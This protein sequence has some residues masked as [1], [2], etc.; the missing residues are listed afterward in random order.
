MRKLYLSQRLDALA[1]ALAAELQNEPLTP[2]TKARVFVPHPAMKEW[3]A[4]E[5]AKRLTLFCGIDLSFF[6]EVASI[7]P[8]DVV[9]LVYQAINGVAECSVYTQ[10]DPQKKASLSVEIAKDFAFAANRGVAPPSDTWQ[11]RLFE[12]ILTGT[13]LRW[14]KDVLDQMTLEGRVHLFGFDAVTPMH[15]SFVNKADELIVYRFSPTTEFW[16]DVKSDA[17]GRRLSL[18]WNKKGA[19]A[20][21][22]QDLK[23]YLADRPA[24]L[25]NWGA[26]GRAALDAIS[27]FETE[28]I[29]APVTSSGLALHIKQRE[30]LYFERAS[31]SDATLQLIKT[32]ST[33]LQEVESLQ[34]R[35][36]EYIRA[37]DAPFSD[38]A[39]YTPQLDLYAPIIEYVFSDPNRPIPYRISELTTKNSDLTDLF[40][41]AEGPWHGGE[42]ATLFENPRFM[43]ARQWDEKGHDQRVAWVK[44][45]YH[46]RSTWEEGADRLLEQMTRLEHGPNPHAKGL[47]LVDE[48]ESVLATLDALQATVASWR[49]LEETPIGWAERLNA[50][51]AEFLNPV[52]SGVH[53]DL[54]RM[55]HV[56]EAIGPIVIPFALATSFLTSSV[57]RQQK[58]GSLLHGV[59]VYPLELGAIFPAKAMFVLGMDDESY[60]RRVEKSSIDACMRVPSSMDEDRYA[61]LQLLHQAEDR[62][63]FSYRHLSP[64]DGKA[65]LPSSLLD[66]LFEHTTSDEPMHE[67]EVPM[68]RLFTCAAPPPYQPTT[69]RLTIDIKDLIAFARNPWKVSLRL[70]YGLRWDYDDED[71]L[72]LTKYRVAQSSINWSRPVA[73]AQELKGLPRGLYGQACSIRLDQQQP[74]CHQIDLLACVDETRHL[75][76]GAIEM[77]PIVL[78]ELNVELVGRL[79]YIP[80]SD[81]TIA[82]GLKQWPERLIVSREL[83]SLQKFV[84]YYLRCK[85]TLTPLHGTWIDAL[86]RRSPADFD[87][88]CP[89]FG[90]ETAWV[91]ERLELPPIEVLFDEWR[92]LRDTFAELIEEYPT[93]AAKRGSDAEL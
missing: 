47:G 54:A 19:L 74:V 12:A 37:T 51:I 91:Y 23:S 66:G 83:A 78:E 11:G 36:G 52:N 33:L 18:Y 68:P 31:V 76:S 29:Y 63:Q 21:Q 82:E 77:A 41:L 20:A 89:A 5:L 27:S 42:I 22:Q 72:P 48:L 69:E 65:L 45:M 13:S 85:H 60:P 15:W 87:D 43:A 3:L 46:L 70:N 49:H 58:N 59:R 30:L 62:L 53:R 71:S 6:E 16:E 92:W 40:R 34:R 84:E 1:D 39:I 80:T 56:E 2:F 50:A 17:E 67:P 64:E 4:L 81:K 88:K 61:L 35:I 38:I 26:L 90:R 8:S 57:S 73:I 93:R 32:G 28:E 25:A 14:P 86:L 44:E 9:P 79:R 75:P 24:L 7:G 55:R 10:G